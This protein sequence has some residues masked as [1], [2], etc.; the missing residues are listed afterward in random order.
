MSSVCSKTWKEAG[1]QEQTVAAAGRHA[2]GE[3]GEGSSGL[4]QCALSAPTLPLTFSLLLGKMSWRQGSLW[5]GEWGRL[6]ENSC[7]TLRGGYNS[8]IAYMRH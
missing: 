6:L 3:G 1:E 7:I 2:C 5:E 8:L 4:G